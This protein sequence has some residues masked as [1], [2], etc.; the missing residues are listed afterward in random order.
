MA[1]E[2]KEFDNTGH[3]QLEVMSEVQT[4]SLGRSLAY[5]IGGI[6][7]VILLS[8]FLPWTQNIRSEG[9]LTAL[10]PQDR[11]Q[12]IEATIAGRIERWHVMEGAFVKK[13]DTI[14][15]IS[16]IKEKYMDPNLLARLGEQVE[17]KQG[18]V[19]ANE[20]KVDALQE[21]ITALREGLIFSLQKAR[22]KIEQTRLKLQSDSMDVVAQRTELAVAISQFER[23][24]NLYKQGLKSLTE[25]EQR[26]LKLQEAQAKLVS[27]INKYEATQAELQNARTEL[28]SLQA[29]YGDKIAK[30]EAELSSTRSYVYGTQAD[31]AKLQSEY[32][33]TQVRSQYYQIVAPQDGYLVRTLKA[34]IGETIKE[35]EALATIMPENPNLAAELYVDALDL[36]LINRGDK[37]RV[38][39]EGWP[40]LVFSGWPDVSFGTFGGKVA[41]I[42]NTAT[43]GKYRMLVVPDP[44]TEPWPDALR[45]GSGVYG[46]AMLNTVPI[47]YEIWRQL[48]N[49]PPDYTN[50]KYTSATDTK[51]KAKNNIK[52]EEEAY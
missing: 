44:D 34:G 43:N 27:L 6:F 17:A 39:F 7:L 3:P 51:G 47:W 25:L 33:S 11:P 23:Q 36:P 29:E 37:V 38:E 1:T 46:W 2:L 41:V 22:N 4:P 14:A 20:N 42:D 18:A 15:S 49:F 21:Q 35:G 50:G 31:V 30:A 40:T 19:A 32:S 5:W 24:E 52:T 26:R 45:V 8:L 48:N 12:T 28:N 16:E 10:T 9:E 13:G